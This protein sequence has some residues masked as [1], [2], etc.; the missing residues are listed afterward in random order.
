MPAAD[1]ITGCDCGARG[2]GEMFTQVEPTGGLQP[3]PETMVIRETSRE[4]LDVPEPDWSIGA[5]ARLF[6][7]FQVDR[8]L[9]VEP[10]LVDVFVKTSNGRWTS[11]PGN[12]VSYPTLSALALAAPV[13]EVYEPAQGAPPPVIGEPEVYYPED[14]PPE[15]PPP[16]YQYSMMT[17]PT[18]PADPRSAWRVSWPMLAIGAG[19][20]WLLFGK[21]RRR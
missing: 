15:L 16:D 7:P 1:Y 6:A 18:Q 13:M 9:W 10:R 4:L 12:D 8:G 3:M 11:Y 5:R 17:S 14:K 2:A 21:R 19:A 20:L